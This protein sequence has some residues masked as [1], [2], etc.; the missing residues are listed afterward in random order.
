MTILYV[1]GSILNHNRF[2]WYFV[3][4][5]SIFALPQILFLVPVM[6][7]SSCICNII[8]KT[9]FYRQKYDIRRCVWKKK[10]INRQI[11]CHWPIFWGRRCFHS[12]FGV[13]I[14]MIS[15]ETQKG[16]HRVLLHL[17]LQLPISH[18]ITTYHVHSVRKGQKIIMRNAKKAYSCGR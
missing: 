4:I 17:L 18:F 11:K 10:A 16:V 13:E 12:L 7:K 8:Q 1:I 6:I 14:K 3:S 9:F 15:L 5:L 2:L